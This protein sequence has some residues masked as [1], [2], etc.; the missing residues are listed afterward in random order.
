VSTQTATPPIETRYY[1]RPWLTHWLVGANVLVFVAMMLKGGSPMGFTTQQ[2]L[3]WGADYGPLTFGGQPWRILTSNYVHF[4]LIH[5]GFNMWCLWNLGALAERML[6]RWTYLLSYTA[7]GIAGSMLSLWWHP[8]VNSVGASGAIFGL[9]GVLITAIY[10]GKL[11]FPKQSLRGISRSLISFAGY[12][13]LFG[14]LPGIDN[15][16][17]MGGLLMGLGLGALLGPFLTQ[18][19]KRRVRIEWVIFIATTFLLIGAFIQVKRVNGYIVPFGRAIDALQR[20]QPEKALPDLAIVAQMRPRD[21]VVQELLGETYIRV[22]DY[23][24]AESAL[25]RVLELKP[26]DAA[27]QFNL[28]LVYGATGRYEDAR[29]AFAAITQR[30]PKNDDAWMMLGSALKAL[31][32]P[33]NAAQALQRAVEINPKNY[34]AYR[35]LGRVQLEQQQPDAALQSFRQALQINNQDRDSLLGM[36]RAYLAKHMSKEAAETFQRYQ[37]LG[38]PPSENSTPDA[39]PAVP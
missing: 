29:Q 2:T 33:A 24:Q 17:H 27:A 20:A 4:S 12:N 37:S 19:V 35:E 1:F 22:K 3:R 34:E 36:G 18:P 5:I 6:G 8:R 39:H 32:E 13:L 21:P 25:K 10:R 28:G 14:F 7:C 30:D 26:S 11:P 23:P 38:P 15:A 9:A 31:H 16:A